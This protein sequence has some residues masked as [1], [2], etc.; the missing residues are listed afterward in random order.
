MY[1]TD[2]PSRAELPST[3]KLLRSTVIAALIAAALLIITVLPAEYGIDPTG[4]GRT[5][6]LTKMG[7]IKVALAAEGAAQKETP[8]STNLPQPAAQTFA[9][10]KVPAAV[11]SNTVSKDKSSAAQQH[12]MTVQLKPGQGAEI[13]LTM[14]KVAQV[15]Y[16]WSTAGGPVNYD[17]HGDPLNAPKGFYHGYGKGRGATGDSGTLQAAFDGSHGWFWRNRSNSNVT[18]TLRT[19]GDYEGIDRVL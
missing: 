1:N 10:P 3:G 19:S 17:T 12:T 18:V 5:L 15:R 14:N 8:A 11:T 6:G 13:K 2:F 7:E 4:I 16:E 9:S